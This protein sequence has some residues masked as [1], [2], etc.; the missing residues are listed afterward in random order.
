MAKVEITT[1]TTSCACGHCC[2]QCCSGTKTD[3]SK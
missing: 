1:I 2:G 3:K